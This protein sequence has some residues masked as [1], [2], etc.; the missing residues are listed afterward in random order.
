MGFFCA[1]QN[2][3]LLT[4]FDNT[5][6]FYQLS[7]NSKPLSVNSLRIFILF[8]TITI[9]L[10]PFQLKGQTDIE[11]TEKLLPSMVDDTAKVQQ[12]LLLGEHYCS[13]DNDKALLFL[14][15]AYSIS[16][17]QNYTE[18]IGK[19]L[20]WLG[21][22]YYYKSNY[23][24]SNRYLDK[25]KRALEETGDLNTLSFWYLAKAF[26][27]RASGDYAHAI[28][29]TTKSIDLCKKTGNKKRMTT[30]YLVIGSTFL[31]RGDADKAM[32]YFREGLSLAKDANN[33]V[34]M[35]NALTSIA[36]SYK[37]K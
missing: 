4:T 10:L 25:A 11:E 9:S 1:L 23:T 5:L 18:G 37:A 24:L 30:C 28:K 35:A 20:M 17:D 22:V 34:V 33:K 36:S 32:K 26:S 8:F 21:R 2:R 7:M 15:D 3:N 27:L 6:S 31:D 12:L 29:M 14:Q 16:I 13:N 19:S